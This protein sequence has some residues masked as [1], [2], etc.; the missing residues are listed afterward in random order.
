MA[1]INEDMT[2]RN[3]TYDLVLHIHQSKASAQ[4]VWQ[5]CLIK[6]THK[7]NFP[8]EMQR[9]NVESGLTDN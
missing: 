6:T 7:V 3:D 5:H 1:S 4:F 9:N 2:L 8:V